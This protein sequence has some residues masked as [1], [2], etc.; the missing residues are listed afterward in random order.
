MLFIIGFENKHSEGKCRI[1]KSKKKDCIAGILV[2]K[3]ELN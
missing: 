2:K 1:G 3:T